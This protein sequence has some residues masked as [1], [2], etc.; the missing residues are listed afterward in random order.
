MKVA[1]LFFHESSSQS[2]LYSL[3]E[4]CF[5]FSPQISVREPE[6]IFIEIGKCKS[7]YS[8]RSF[9]LR[10]QSLARRLGWVAKIALSHDIPSSLALARHSGASGSTLNSLPIEALI[11]FADPFGVDPLGRKSVRVM[12]ESLKSLGVE[13]LSEF[14]QIPTASLPSRFGGLSLLCRQRLESASDLL[15][16]SWN[17][18]EHFKEK[19]ELLPSEYCSEIEPLLFYSKAMLDRLFSRLRGR[20]LR[21]ERISFAIEL[22]KYSTVKNPTRE[23]TFELITPQGSTLGFLP[24]LR[25]RL[26]RDLSQAPIHSFVHTLRCS[27]LATTAGRST[28]KDFFN[29]QDGNSHL[30]HQE[31]LGSLFGELEEFLGKNHV[32]WARTTEERLP[33]KSWVRSSQKG[34]PQAD[35][36]NRYPK[37]PTRI[38]KS[39]VPVSIIQD[40]I[41]FKGRKF[42]S[43]C[44]SKLERLSLD[45]LN[46][47][48]A[49]NYYQVELEG[50]R[51]LWIFSDPQHHYFVHGYYE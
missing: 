28:Q 14:K 11:D 3:A 18:P 20:S 17:P 39:P 8:D 42:K 19:L 24:I 40:R 51:T 44:W 43:I 27:V 9:V 25:E 30:D 22:E 46:D 38:F 41:L 10:A 26:N 48:H 37:R 31:V 4:A 50:G 12:I 6:A 7:L 36:E 2:S 32:F 15:W 23:W 13:T 29:N 35:L 47:T 45:W 16:P 33:E 1:C 5:R 49:R 34:A 21:A